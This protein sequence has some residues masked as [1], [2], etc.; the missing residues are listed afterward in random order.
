MFGLPLSTVVIL[1]VIVALP[2]FAYSLYQVD[3]DRGDG[4]VTVFGHR[5]PSTQ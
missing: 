2:M 3:R 1:G 4:S 5:S